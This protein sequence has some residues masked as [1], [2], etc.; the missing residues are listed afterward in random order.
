MKETVKEQWNGQME[1]FMKVSGLKEFSMATE[2]WLT[3]MENL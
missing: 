1:V 2:R 3:Q